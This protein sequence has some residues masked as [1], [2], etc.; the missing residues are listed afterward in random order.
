MNEMVDVAI[1]GAGPYGLSIAAHLLA[2]N[3]DVRVFGS[4]M[5]TWR[6][7][8]PKGMML[9]SEGFASS[10]SDPANSFT[11]GHFCREQ[12]I[13]YDDIGRPVP[14]ETFASYGEAFQRR[15]V[16]GLD[17]R[18]IARVT[19]EHEGF[20][21]EIRGGKSLL[22]RR[23]VVAT[24]IG[25]YARVPAE[26]QDLPG[27]ALTHS[28]HHADYRRFADRDV[29]VIGAGASAL[30][31]AAA[32]RRAGARATLVTRR[33]SV[34]FYEAG[35]PR[36]TIDA[37][38]APIT[39]L[40]PGWKKWLC[41]A[42]PGLFHALP[43]RLRLTIVQRYL[44]PSPGWHV[45]DTIEGHVPYRL[46]STV[47]GAT[48]SADGR[49]SLAI[50][51]KGEGRSTLEVD[52]VVA[53]TGYKVEVERLNLIDPELLAGIATLDGSPVLSRHFETSV[54]GLY[55]VG[56][57]SAYSFGPMF[58]FACGAD[59]AARRLAR[60]FRGLR[61]TAAKPSS[62]PVPAGLRPRTARG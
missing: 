60:R 34:R 47:A 20:R 25:A 27:S 40:G 23:V 55:F 61:A 19:R 49:V 14:V 26:L 39:P 36:R 12:G 38:L 3:L 54:P 48:L 24:G 35:R 5:R 32:L 4:P 53:A 2:Q 31:A 8:M 44:G 17:T 42:V 28:V 1:V 50:D 59:Y 30:D 62:V 45:R 11:L 16:P 41:C 22:A 37:L 9:K 18:P 6:T 29:A 10:L 56:T 43:E 33:S 7:N 51:R 57:P 21:L 58:R 15:F 46:D 52:H 13:P